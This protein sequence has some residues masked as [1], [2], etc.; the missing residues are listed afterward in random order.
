MKCED[1]LSSVFQ[2]TN[3]QDNLTSAASAAAAIAQV[4]ATHSN[5]TKASAATASMAGIHQEALNN[6]TTAATPTAEPAAHPDES[7]TSNSA[8]KQSGTGGTISSLL[9]KVGDGMASLLGGAD[10]RIY[11]AGL[12]AQQETF[13]LPDDVS[14]QFQ[15][16]QQ[17]LSGSADRQQLLQGYQAW[18]DQIKAHLLSQ[19]DETQASDDGHKNSQLPPCL[20]AYVCMHASALLCGVHRV[21]MNMK[22]SFDHQDSCLEFGCGLTCCDVPTG[23]P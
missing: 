13:V 17:H 19:Y 7:A 3:M 12:T 20:H 2:A 16:L 23:T 4:A 18:L 9:A 14:A 11:N 8:I 15:V 22:D 6:S 1:K 5:L 21:C 10:K